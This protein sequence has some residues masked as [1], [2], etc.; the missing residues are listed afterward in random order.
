[1]KELKL[2]V[3]QHE[4]YSMIVLCDTH[5]NYILHDCDLREIVVY[6]KIDSD[7]F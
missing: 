3:L 2:R 7:R 6:L 5:V 4:M 1:M